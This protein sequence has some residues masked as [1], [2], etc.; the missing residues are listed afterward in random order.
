[1][2]GAPS[3]CSPS[4]LSPAGAC[5]GLGAAL[6]QAKQSQGRAGHRARGSGDVPGERAVTAQLGV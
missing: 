3:C 1:M 2:G 6:G 4:S 5:L